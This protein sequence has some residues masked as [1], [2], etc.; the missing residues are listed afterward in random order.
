MSPL[1]LSLPDIKACTPLSFPLMRRRKSGIV[2]LSVTLAGSPAPLVV[3]QVPSLTITWRDS[4][5]SGVVMS[6]WMTAVF[7]AAFSGRKRSA[8][9]LKMA[10]INPSLPA[11]LTKALISSSLR[12]S[13]RAARSCGEV[14][15]PPPAPDGA[16]PSEVAG[17]V[18]APAASG[19]ICS[20]SLPGVS[21][22]VTPPSS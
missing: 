18:P 17:T 12:P 11:S 4:T 15:P 9:P 13:R 21:A 3:L 10:S 22:M 6:Y 2:R 14:V 5:P 16:V 20:G 8:M 19:P 1:S 7:P